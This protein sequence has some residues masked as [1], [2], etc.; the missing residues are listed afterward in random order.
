MY[1]LKGP[2]QAKR[3]HAFQKGKVALP[4]ITSRT[5]QFPQQ[6]ISKISLFLCATV[7]CQRFYKIIEDTNSSTEVV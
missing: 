1:K 5:K 4:K 2:Q 3:T 7:Y 6:K